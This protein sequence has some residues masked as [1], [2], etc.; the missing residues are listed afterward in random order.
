MADQSDSPSPRRRR[1]SLFWVNIGGV[2]LA[3]GALVAAAVYGADTGVDDTPIIDE[4][5]IGEDEAAVETAAAAAVEGFLPSSGQGSTCT[6]PIGVDL[7]PGFGAT[8]TIN[9]RPIP[10]GELNRFETDP[11]QPEGT[12]LQAGASL[13]QYTWGPEEG[14]PNGELIRARDNVVQACVYRLED[15]PSN[16][17]IVTFRFDAL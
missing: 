5:F 14:C 10:D 12:V 4:E 9:G 17:R 3:V 2:T 1:T 16:C 6:E 7:A 8:L 15:G 13:N 11:S